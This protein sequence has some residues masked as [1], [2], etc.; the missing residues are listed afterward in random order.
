M[1]VVNSF[2]SLTCYKKCYNIHFN[3][4]LCF[5]F[6]ALR[7]LLNKNSDILFLYYEILK[8]ATN[9]S[10]LVFDYQ[11]IVSRYS[12]LECML[13]AYELSLF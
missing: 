5:F 3:G 1:L 6:L 8:F 11:R 9:S 13:V 7:V 2:Y 10:F 4:L 12:Y